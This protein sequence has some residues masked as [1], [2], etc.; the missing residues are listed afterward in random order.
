MTTATPEQTV[1][2]IFGTRPEAIKLA[3]VLHELSQRPRCRVVNVVTSQHTDLLTP[4]LR[5]FD[6]AVDH[7]L[8]AMAPG[9][10]LNLL[11]SKV[12]A[13]VDGVL[14]TTSAD[15]VLVQGD[16]TSALAGAIAAFQRGV[17]VAHVEAGLRSDDPMSPFPEEM[18]RRL[19]SKLAQFHFAP[20]ARNAAAL[21]AEGADPASVV[22][23][24]NP[25]VDAVRWIL[26]AKRPSATIAREIE[27]VAGHRLIVLTTHRRE[28]FGATMRGHLET[29]RRFLET[30]PD[31]ALIFPV[32]SNPAVREVSAEVFAG[33]DRARL[34]APLDYADFLHL[35]AAAWLIVSDSGGVQEEVPSLGRPLLV[36]RENT[37]RPEAI[38]CGVAKLVGRSPERLW[39][40]LNEAA[41]ENSWTTTVDRVANPFG[42]GDSAVR[43]ADAVEG[44]LGVRGRD[45]D[46]DRMRLH[47][48]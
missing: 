4:F 13:A 9:Q 37:E 11:L 14:A 1:L 45:E 42:R 25:V 26:R 36:L 48:R 6:I 28:N 31:V 47:A 8:R 7:D 24:G 34:I 38:E 15:L 12:I 44:I 17:P 20:T 30:R 16:T 5:L 40:L 35:M 22:V 32:H 46:F 3:P 41:A 2:S 27:A 18:N 29:L 33:C 19:I 43:I 39:A 21:C 10:H 23:T